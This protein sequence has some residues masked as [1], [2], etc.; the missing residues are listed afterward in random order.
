MNSEPTPFEDINVGDTVV[1][2][3]GD[4]IS[5]SKSIYV[6]LVKEKTEFSLRD[7]TGTFPMIYCQ[8]FRVNSDTYITVTGKNLALI[9]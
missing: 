9:A 6:L 1:A 3:W 4:D 2:V 7:R 8:F 5:T